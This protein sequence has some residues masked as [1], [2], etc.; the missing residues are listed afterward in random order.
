MFNDRLSLL[1]VVRGCSKIR[2]DHLL[3]RLLLGLIGIGVKRAL[4]PEDIQIVRGHQAKMSSNILQ[5]GETGEGL[6]VDRVT[7][8]VERARQVDTCFHR[9]GIVGHVTSCASERCLVAALGLLY[10]LFDV[11][12]LLLRAVQGASRVLVP[13]RVHDAA[14]ILFLEVVLAIQRLYL[15]QLGQWRCSPH[16]SRSMLLGDWTGTFAL[17]RQVAVLEGSLL[18][19]PALNEVTGVLL[20]LVAS[21]GPASLVRLGVLLADLDLRVTLALLAQLAHLLVKQVLQAFGPLRLHLVQGFLV[22]VGA[23]RCH[24]LV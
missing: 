7:R 13:A 23:C 20:S 10:Q 22:S 5:V 21:P 3:Y 6:A 2:T 1:V 8:Q 11:H 17:S 15:G 4:I 9:G 16:L 12:V 24:V 14:V 19:I 18:Q